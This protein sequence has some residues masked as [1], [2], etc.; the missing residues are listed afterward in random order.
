MPTGPSGIKP[1]KSKQ[2][3]PHKRGDLRN[4]CEHLLLLQAS[5]AYCGL[6]SRAWRIDRFIGI[7]RWE[8]PEAADEALRVFYARRRGGTA[9][10][11][12]ES[13]HSE[14]EMDAESQMR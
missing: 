5:A 7:E 6:C 3:K 12:D 4:T 11:E 13:G 1:K 14:D 9:L 8:T 10:A 2:D